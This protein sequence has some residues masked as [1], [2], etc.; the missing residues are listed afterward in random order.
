MTA[1]AKYWQPSSAHRWVSCHGAPMMCEK[2][3]YQPSS[4]AADEGTLAHSIAEHRLRENQWPDDVS[5]E[6]RDYLQLYVDCVINTPNIYGRLHPEDKVH[7]PSIHESCFG[8]VDNWI[9]V[10]EDMTLYVDD[11][12]YGWGLVE[13]WWQHICYASGLIDKLDLSDDYTIVMRVIQPRPWHK[14]GPVREFRATVA[15]L[16]PL[17]QQ[18]HDA[19]NDLDPKLKA[20]PHCKYCRAITKCP[21]NY[22]M[23][24]KAID[25]A[26]QN[27]SIESPDPGA[28]LIIL[29]EAFT[30]IKNRKSAKESELETMIK[31][32][33][34]NQFFKIGKGGGAG[35]SSWV[36]S[37]NDVIAIGE[38]MGIDL[39]SNALITP[40]QAIK[41]GVPEEIVKANSKMPEAKL[42][43][44]RIDPNEVS[45]IFEG[46]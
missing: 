40:V 8:T 39:K 25:V 45:K 7:C 43:L 24:L 20:G 11:L 34:T 32:G 4:E 17:I 1:H 2:F 18:L 5:D 29:E 27:I 6:M 31:M 19:A 10:V 36:A 35:R 15:E 30:A 33:G 9:L 23:V 44:V 28:E 26:E 13:H 3:P 46:E 38:M 14:D 22:R 37:T 42:K 21:A 12:K 16:K 41:K